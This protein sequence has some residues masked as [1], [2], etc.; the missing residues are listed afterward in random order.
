[1][2]RR[3]PLAILVAL[4]LLFSGR[5]LT[6]TAIDEKGYVNIGGI[7][8]W[9][10]ISGNDIANPVVLFVHGGPGTAATPWADDIFADWEKDFTLVQWDQR[11]AGR[12][13]AKS[14]PIEPPITVDRMVQ[15]GVEL[16][17]YLTD[18]LRKKKIILVGGSWGSI[19]GAN[20]AHTRPDLFYAYVGQAQIVNWWENYSASYSKMKELAQA[21]KDHSAI[22][23]IDEIG[24]PPWK[25]FSQ[26]IKFRKV[27]QQYQMK[28]VPQPHDYRISPEYLSVED[29]AQWRAA[30][31]STFIRFAASN[32][33][34]PF[35]QMN[36]NGPLAHVD[37]RSLGRDFPLPMLI[38]MGAEDLTAIPA[39]AKSWLENLAAPVKQF[40]IVPAN[41]HD[42]SP[43]LI[44]LTRKAITERVVPLTRE[45]EYP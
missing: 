35:A 18:R 4:S 17:E 12:T 28:L 11:G 25:L 37:L 26:Y 21:A 13:F 10:T 6:A 1:M 20:M 23:A 2:D 5:A 34:G 44:G 7:K 24:P 36:F 38:I 16:T 29:R 33:D 31:D 22:L 40:H 43:A 3:K 14:G 30:D 15:D 45:H 8:Q 9:V 27:Q 19:L 32:F 41:G 42:L 39:I